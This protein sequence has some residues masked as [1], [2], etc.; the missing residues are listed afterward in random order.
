MAAAA[1]APEPRTRSDGALLATQAV[2]GATAR[3]RRA[4]RPALAD[5]RADA[6]HDRRRS[7]RRSRS[8]RARGA[9]QAR[10]ALQPDELGQISIHLSQ[11]S[12]GLLARVTADTAAA[13]QAL[14]DGR[15]ELHQS[16]SSLGVS[17]LRLDIGSSGQSQTGDREEGFAGRAL[18]RLRRPTSEE[19]EGVEATAAPDGSTATAAHRERRAR[20]RARLI[21]TKG[22]THMTTNPLHS[23]G[24]GAAAGSQPAARPAENP[25]GI[26]GQNDFLKL[27]VA[28]LQAQ[29]PLEPGNSNE[30]IN[31]LAQFTQVEQTTNLASAERA[32][33]RR[34][35][36][37]T[38]RRLQ[39]PPSGETASG[40]VQSVQSTRVR[41]DRDD[42]RRRGRQAREHHGSRMSP[43]SNPALVPPGGLDRGGRAGRAAPARR[44]RAHGGAA[45]RAGA[46]GQSFA[47]ALDAGR[48]R[49]SSCSS[50][51]HALARV[52][53]RGIELDPATLGR[54]SQGVGRAASK[55]SRDSLVLVDG[56][57]FVV[58]V[59]NRTVITAVGSEH[60]KDNVFTNIDSAVIA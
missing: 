29:N 12:E 1:A 18:E 55:G 27:M 39:R 31:E 47:D 25:N 59:S 33:E 34:Q 43:I 51:S 3:S 22:T 56:T 2:G 26:L 48:Q 60:M 32:L 14:A 45:A 6:G 37:R 40:N 7:T 20:G 4:A 58:S 8:R 13:A 17:L 11:T 28:Q 53:R 21:T 38:Q 35:A 44:R 42:R 50:P 9:T 49:R 54:L 24:G 15:A 41:H 10:I 57:A 30:F 5:G 19:A 16:L 23:R 36:D 52:Q 46:G